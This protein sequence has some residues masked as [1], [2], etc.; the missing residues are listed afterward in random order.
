MRW[1]LLGGAAA[2]LAVAVAAGVVVWVLGA[3]SNSDEAVIDKLVSDFAIAV[4]QDD[5]D[6]IL[7]LLCA[8]EA[9]DITEDDDY[10]PANNGGPIVD[11]GPERPVKAS[12]I[13]VTGNTAS[14][15]ITRPDQPDSTLTFR[16]ESGH[17][18]VCA[19]AGDPA[20]PTPTPTG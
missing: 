4:D 6:K 5:Q 19:P 7:G 12:D 10:D 15:R 3:R 9:L 20:T 13:R 17:W 18:R 1:W 16:K 8:E 11:P 2:V 14:A